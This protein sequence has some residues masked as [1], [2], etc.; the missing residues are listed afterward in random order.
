MHRGVWTE[1]SSAIARA[2]PR[3]HFYPDSADERLEIIAPRNR[4]RYVAY[5]VLENQVPPQ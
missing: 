1:Q 4:Y 5:G 3:R 2:Q